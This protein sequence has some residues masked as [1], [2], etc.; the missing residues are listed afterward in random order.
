MP[1]IAVIGSMNV[2]LVSR[3]PRFLLPGETLTGLSFQVFPGG[4]G[5][6]QAVAASRLLPEVMMLGKLGDDQNGAL[7]RQVLVESAID[8]ACVE[9]VPGVNNGTTV[10]EVAA[11]SGNN[12]IIYFP[13][14]NLLVDRAQIDRY[15]ER[16]M[17]CDVFLMQLEIPLETVT[18]AAGRLRGA[19][20]TVILDPAP[21][22]PL[23]EELL[24]HVDYI[25]PNEVELAILT[26]LETGSPGKLAAAGR[27]LVR[28]GARAVVAKAGTDGAYLI[29]G[30]EEIHAPGFRVAA[31]DTTAAGDSFNAGFAAGLC[32]GMPE[33]EALRFANAV[34]ALSTLGSGA[35]GAMPNYD[36]VTK[37]LKS[38]EKGKQK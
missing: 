15:W 6:N 8:G 4:K 13:G 11:D 34:G 25:T 28:M 31:V 10:I 17:S 24:S 5:G 3:V 2:D 20:K 27:K 26:G 14:A 32:R 23:T 36:T 9:T 30:D 22:V 18:Y 35:Q 21:A 12:R 29:R 16:L 33:K 38:Q 7:Y 37:F 1:R 19:G